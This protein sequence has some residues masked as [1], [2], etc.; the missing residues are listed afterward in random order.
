[1]CIFGPPNTLR[2]RDSQLAY[3]PHTCRLMV[4]HLPKALLLALLV[5]RKRIG[6]IIE[7]KVLA[8]IYQ[9]SLCSSLCSPV[10]CG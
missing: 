9:Y 2:Q 6:N 4:K 1:M 3:H 7:N 10:P 5:G 8:Q